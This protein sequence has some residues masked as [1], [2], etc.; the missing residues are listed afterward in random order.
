MY[1]QEFKEQISEG[2]AIETYVQATDMDEITYEVVVDHIRRHSSTSSSSS[3][4]PPPLPPL[5]SLLLPLVSQL[6]FF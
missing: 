2:Q 6:V 4:S 1:A 3:F 5:P